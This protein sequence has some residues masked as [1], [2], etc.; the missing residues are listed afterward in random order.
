MQLRPL[1]L[2]LFALMPLSFSTASPIDLTFAVPVMAV[3][4]A[5][6]LGM[7]NML[8]HSISDPKLEAWVNTEMR[9]FF[10]AVVL[11]VIITGSLI[12]SNGVA[13]ALTGS[14][15]FIGAAQGIVD[16][17]LGTYDGAFEY[18]IKAAGRIRAA[19][20]YSP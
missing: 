19:A 14:D 16:G 1:A 12:G 9:E 3:V 17:W 6:F 18:V 5:A 7:A 20:T 2:F 15:T 4:V 11:I 10:A 13:V 8:S